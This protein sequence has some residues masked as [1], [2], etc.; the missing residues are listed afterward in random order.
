MLATW[1]EVRSSQRK[2]IINNPYIYALS[3]AI[4]CTAWTFYGSVGRVTTNGIDFL[5][6]YLGPSIVMFSGWFVVRKILRICKIQR[7]TSV[8]DFISARYGKSRSL[9][10]LVTIISLFAGIPYIGLQLK[11]INSSFSILTGINRNNNFEIFYIVIILIIFTILFGTRKIE[12]NEKHEGMVFSIAIESVLKLISFVAVGVFVTFFLFDGFNDIFSKASVNLTNQ[13][14]SLNVSMQSSNWF[15]HVLLSGSVFLLLPRQFQVIVVEN[16]DEKHLAQ[17]LWLFPLYMLIINIFVIPIAIGGN[18]LLLQKGISPD[19]Y[20]MGLPLEF[21]QNSLALLVYIGGFSAATSMII[22]E[23][24]AISIML[25]NNVFLPYV[26][27]NESTQLKFKKYPA[28]YIQLFRRVTI[29]LIIILG[30]IYFRYISNQYSLVSIGMVAFVAVLQFAPSFFGGIFWKRGTERGAFVGMLIGFFIW[31][32]WLILPSIL[33]ASNPNELSQNEGV[34]F[35]FILKFFEIEGLDMISNATFWSLFLNISVYYLVSIF[36]EQSS[37][38]HNQANL[39]VDVFKYSTSHDSAVVWRGSARM[40]DIKGL[41]NSFVGASKS[42]RLLRLFSARNKVEIEDKYADPQ[43]VKYVEKVLVGIVGSTSAR[44]LVASVAKEESIST[45]EVVE[46]LKQTQALLES[47]KELEKKTAELKRIT[48]ELSKKNEQLEVMDRLKDDFLTTVTHEI[49][50]PLTSI[51]ALS[52]ILVDN[53][54]LTKEEREQFI[55]T[56]I[57][58]SERMGRL[59]NQV[60]DLEKYDSGKRKLTEEQIVINKLISNVIH[61]LDAVF[62]EKRIKIKTKFAAS[63]DIITGDYDKLFQ[64]ILNLLSNAIKFVKEGDGRIHVETNSD[65]DYLNIIV[66]DN[67]PGID[68]VYQELIF[69]KFY[70][71]E[72]QSIRKPKGTGLGLAIS[73]R[74]IELH[75][76]K[77]EVKSEKGNGATFIIGLPLTKESK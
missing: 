53:E 68:K 41:L 73:K 75:K 8:A 62:L 48:D 61:T 44:M 9:G 4:Y 27:A 40:N 63:V 50:T 23:T 13:V 52:E 28:F 70:Q 74:I 64:V 43:I 77:I 17:A 39:F 31:F 14:F 26:L 76:G 1:A 69:E 55:E 29:A 2:S 65:A 54:D 38:E 71:A 30:F 21:A 19:F 20:V 37:I 16:N 18:V 32:I 7:I 49:R 22:V 11:A 66:S 60:L 3:L 45:E 36:T 35:N 58:E 51:K 25:S 34:N 59:I 33:Y 56:I 5:S 15:W 24:I 47:N 6:V 67:G 72:N 42:E 12:A 46:I 57:N 10:V